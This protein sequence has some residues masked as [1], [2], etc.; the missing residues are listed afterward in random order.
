MAF[1]I[2]KLY[3][4]ELSKIKSLVKVMSSLIELSFI[5]YNFIKFTLY[6][7]E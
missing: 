6:N 5:K 3:V 4:Y 7:M 2:K 1:V